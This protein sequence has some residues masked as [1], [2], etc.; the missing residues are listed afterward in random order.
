VL[1][2]HVLIRAAAGPFAA[3]ALYAE[4]TGAGPYAGLA[5]ADF[6]ACL[7][8]AATGGYALRAYDR[9]QRLKQI[10]P[11]LWA[12]R[13]PRAARAIR[14]NLGT[15]VDTEKV[16]VRMKGRGGA[17]LG[18]VEETFAAS[19]TPGDSFLIGGQVVRHEG[20][21]E[22]TVEVSRAPGREPKV[23]VFMGTKLAT[24]TL[25]SDRV[26][27][28]L[29]DPGA[30]PLPRHIAGWLA[31]QRALSKLPEPGRLLI[32]S[33]AREGRAHTCVHGFAGRNAQQTLGLLLTHRM[34][35]EGLG[36]LGF[37]ATDYATLIWGLRPVPDAAALV[38]AEGLRAALDTWLAGNAV[39]KRT[40]RS[41]AIVAGLI[42]RN[43]P[44]RRSSARQATFSS[45]IL[46]D[47][48]RTYDPGHL[49][50]RITRDEAMRGLV[51]FGRIEAMLARTAGRI[52]H[53]RAGHVTPLAAP[54]LLEAGRVPITASGAAELATAEAARLMAEAG[55]DPAAAPSA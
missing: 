30:H 13:D 11:G 17:P 14:M 12:L 31:T 7:D 25:L 24:S 35:A 47:T 27:A 43:Q 20:L 40:F 53:V 34:E 48:L 15:I 26:Q 51:D 1:C 9:W 6:D 28:I 16:K 42:G 50:L 52:D 41:V 10:E 19:L 22:M 33:F 37:V 23:P 18:E 29:A 32:E 3:D 49:L 5:R 55:L 4:V 36:P 2:Q 44:G 38:S 45:D 8:F 21:R 46:Y 39:M 54:L